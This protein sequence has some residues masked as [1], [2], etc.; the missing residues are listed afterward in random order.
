MTHSTS[1]QERH[2][3]LNR[4]T[5]GTELTEKPNYLNIYLDIMLDL[6]GY[7]YEE[8]EFYKMMD[9][10]QDQS[11]QFRLTL[12]MLVKESRFGTNLHL[13][14]EYGCHEF[15]TNRVRDYIHTILLTSDQGA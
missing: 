8:E 11:P 10:I 6:S 12:K 7:D 13:Y 3:N 4:I 14:T 5:I 15:I 2:S 9:N 1:L